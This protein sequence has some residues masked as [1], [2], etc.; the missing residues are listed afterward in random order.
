MTASAEAQDRAAERAF[1]RTVSVSATGS[2]SA[3]PDIARISTGVVTEGATAREALDANTRS[4][5]ALID[6]LKGL[7]IDAKDIQTANIAVEPRYHQPKDGRPATINGYR[8]VNQV[9]IVLRDIAKVGETLDRGITLGANQLGGIAFE[10]S[11]AETLKDEARR[12][13]MANALRR[14]KL[15]ATAAGAQVDRVLTISETSV[16]PQPRP[17]AGGARMAMSEAVP[18]E[19][20]QQ[21]LEA[22][23]RVT[24]S[25]K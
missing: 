11:R 6:G 22:T 5:R 15:Y 7:G 20:G 14:A 21:S 3:Q 13:A 4:M 9:R 19:A 8:V 16:G 12:Q 25:L 1:E 10:V 24:W 23:V 17:M 2:A 18:V